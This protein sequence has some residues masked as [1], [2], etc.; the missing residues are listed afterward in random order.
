MPT[1]LIIP[2]LLLKADEILAMEG[3]SSGFISSKCYQSNHI[4]TVLDLFFFFLQ[5]TSSQV[6]LA[7]S[8][9]SLGKQ[10][11]RKFCDGHKLLLECFLP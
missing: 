4:R 11:A 2:K 8:F 10:Q 9:C 3:S 1:I 7:L 6:C 5:R